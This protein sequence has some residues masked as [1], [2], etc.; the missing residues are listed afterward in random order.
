MIVYVDQD[1]KPVSTVTKGGEVYA[2]STSIPVVDV[3]APTSTSSSVSVPTTT[4]IPTVYVPTVTSS[5]SSVES[6]SRTSVSSSA[7]A[8]S[9]AASVPAGNGMGLTYSPYNSDGSCKSAS[10]VLQDFEGF[11][12]GYAYIRTYGTDC[13]T[14]STVLAACKAHGLKLFAGVFSLSGLSDQVSDII[15]AFDGDFSDLYAVSVGNELVNSGAADAAT[16]MAAVK[17][18]RVQ[19]RAAGYTGPVVTVDTLVAARANPILCDESD[20]CPVNCHPFFDGNVEASGSGD[21]LISQ[22]A[23][24]KAVLADQNQKIVVAETGWPWKGDTNGAAVPSVSNQE[25]ALSSIKSAFSSNPADVIL[26]NP[27]NMHWKTSSSSQ[28][29][30]EPYWGFLGECPSG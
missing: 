2:F 13:N 18:A 9:S 6:T 1:G 10:G 7:A 3:P 16:V 11:G 21:F 17:A 28:F 12:S 29:D 24:L 26:F 27:Y 23:T 22:L 4:S 25:A 5:V 14:V 19:L 8:S 20:F 15:S 30:A